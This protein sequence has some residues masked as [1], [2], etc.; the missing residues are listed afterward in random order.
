[1]L[2]DG[3]MEPYLHGRD[4]TQG[5]FNKTWKTSSPESG[6]KKQARDGVA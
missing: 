5:E 3:A 6:G 2:M 1:M 4:G